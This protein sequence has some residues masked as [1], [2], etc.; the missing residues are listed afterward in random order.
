MVFPLS[1]EACTEKHP[2]SIH[3]TCVAPYVE[4]G[5][6]RVPIDIIMVASNMNQPLLSHR[7]CW[8]LLHVGSAEK[9]QQFV[10]FSEET[11]RTARASSD[12]VS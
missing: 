10:T 2:S 9:L 7:L 8:C 4:P 11:A 5:Q 3:T 6:T 12:V 1:V